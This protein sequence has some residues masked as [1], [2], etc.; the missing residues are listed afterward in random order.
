MS[1]SD[2]LLRLSVQTK[3]LR[4]GKSVANQNSM[5]MPGQEAALRP[6]SP[7]YQFEHFPANTLSRSFRWISFVVRFSAVSF[8]SM[9]SA[10]PLMMGFTRALTA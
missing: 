9:M 5:A 10:S 7:M 3:A 1:L 8:T 6:K 2:Q 4:S